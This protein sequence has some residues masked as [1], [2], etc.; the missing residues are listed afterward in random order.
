MGHARN[1]AKN[2]KAAV[3]LELHTMPIIKNMRA[4]DE[5]VRC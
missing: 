3:K 4:V 5:R 2:Q 1:L